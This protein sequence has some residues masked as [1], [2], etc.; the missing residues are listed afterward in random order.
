[1]EASLTVY[2]ANKKVLET[3]PVRAAR[4]DA[5]R[6]TAL[7]VWFELPLNDISPGKYECQVNLIDEFGRKFAFPRSSFA[8]VAIPSKPMPH[9]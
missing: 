8:I 6:Q 1:V 5:Q 7:P 2:G 9:S 4:V 3:R